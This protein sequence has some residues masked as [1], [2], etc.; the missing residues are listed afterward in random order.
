MSNEQCI[1]MGVAEQIVTDFD[2][3][4][5]I[6][7]DSDKMDILSML[8]TQTR[9]WS[10]CWIEFKLFEC[11]NIKMALRVDAL[12]VEFEGV[13]SVYIRKD[14]FDKS[15]LKIETE[16]STITFHIKEDE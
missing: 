14:I 5:D 8:T 11:Q 1:P 2:F 15:T 6:F 7:N 10:N 12:N 3:I 4:A 16:N 13:N 9:Y